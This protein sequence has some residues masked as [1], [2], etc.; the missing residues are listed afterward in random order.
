MISLVLHRNGDRLQRTLSD[1]IY[2][3]G[4]E[5]PADLVIADGTISAIHAEVHVQGETC[6]VRDLGS[7][8]GTFL[9]GVPLRS[10]TNVGPADRLQ[11][12]G[13]TA[14]IEVVRTPPPSPRALPTDIESSPR[15]VRRAMQWSSRSWFGAGLA[16]AT[17]I[18][19]SAF[20][21]AYSASS[22]RSV[23]RQHHFASLAAQYTNVLTP[24]STSVPP[25]ATDD[26]LRNPIRV[27]NIDGVV[28]YPAG[29]AKTAPSP[30]IDPSTRKVYVSAKEGLFRIPGHRSLDGEAIYSFPVRNGGSLM[31]YVSAA[32]AASAN[33]AAAFIAGCTLLAGLLSAIVLLV[34]MRPVHEAVRTEIA[35]LQERIS[36]VMNGVID[37]LPR[38]EVFP[39]LNAVAAAIESG[40][41]RGSRGGHA[42]L[43]GVR[44]A[45]DDDFNA[46]VV[47]LAEQASIAYCFADANYMLLHVSNTIHKFVEFAT[48]SPGQSLFANTLSTAQARELVQALNSDG[49]GPPPTLELQRGPGLE[50]VAVYTVRFHQGDRTLY[51]ILFCA[52]WT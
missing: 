2:R 1:G 35:R 49:S 18:L 37:T 8:N 12:G 24:E 48:V 38:S 7:R 11:F 40:L 50:R 21:L 36:A 29:T 5:H 28:L 47:Q 19:I 30:L 22:N 25:P 10:A 33:S 42:R 41:P 43:G 15:A 14:T 46:Q 16:M 3:L 17:S 26:S 23:L 51:G 6:V 32:E 9:N 13:V 34:V 39:E 27:H 4:R 44:H 31:G 45:G 52:P 20:I